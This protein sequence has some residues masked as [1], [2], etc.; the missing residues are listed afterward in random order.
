LSLK[1]LLLILDDWEGLIA[2][3]PVWKQLE[4]FVDIKFL[5]APIDTA[6]GNELSSVVFLMAIRERTALTEQVFDRLP[7]LKL[8]L[9]TGGHAYHIDQQAAQKRGIAIALGRRIKAPLASVPELTMAMMLGVMHL[10][11]QA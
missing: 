5:P 1:P 11:P 3:S 6:P 8:V 10:L 4:E 7:K 2:K 9:Q